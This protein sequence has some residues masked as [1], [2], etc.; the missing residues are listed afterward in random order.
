MGSNAARSSTVVR[1]AGPWVQIN[2]EDAWL[3][4]IDNNF[5]ASCLVELEESSFLGDCS[6]SFL[7]GCGPIPGTV[8]YDYEKA[9][10]LETS[11]FRVASAIPQRL[12]V[13]GVPSQIISSEKLTSLPMVRVH[14]AYNNL[15]T[16][17]IATS[18]KIECLQDCGGVYVEG[19]LAPVLNGIANFSTFLVNST[20]NKDVTFK[21]SLLNSTGDAFLNDGAYLLVPHVPIFSK[22]IRN[23]STWYDSIEIVENPSD[24]SFNATMPSW[25]V[26]RID[27]VSMSVIQGG[28]LGNSSHTCSSQT[29]CKPA[30]SQGFIQG[31]LMNLT[32]KGK[33]EFSNITILTAG[34]GFFLSAEARLNAVNLV[35]NSGEF[36]VLERA[37]GG[38]MV[39]GCPP[40]GGVYSVQEVVEGLKVLR[41]Y[42]T[43]NRSIDSTT[44]GISLVKNLSVA[45]HCLAGI[46][47]SSGFCYV[48]ATSVQVYGIGGGYDL[49]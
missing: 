18:T 12:E 13:M 46:C 6:R 26:L 48:N 22:V 30:L 36:S 41:L 38:M 47:S 35:G 5:S 7:S 19:N 49:G 29:S 32:N 45:N 39:A 21:F 44:D 33:G 24:A 3:D 11:T 42:S 25:P 2:L 20:A 4:P 40:A 37:Y 31:Q 34:Y 28:L 43:D 23:L 15:L 27:F 10:V 16:G 17:E 9:D 1:I 14:G 8:G